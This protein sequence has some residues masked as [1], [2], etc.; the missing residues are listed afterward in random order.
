M[1]KEVF[2]T[3]TAAEITPV[4]QI[5]EYTFKPDIICKLLIEE[6]SKATGQIFI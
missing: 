2:C 5:G 4:S 6:Y 3:G 1:A